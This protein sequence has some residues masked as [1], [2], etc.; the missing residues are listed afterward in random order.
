[1]PLLLNP[2]ENKF[3]LLNKTLSQ[4]QLIE[5]PE[6]GGGGGRVSQEIEFGIV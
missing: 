5:H 3:E 2:C 6:S 1:M 4:N